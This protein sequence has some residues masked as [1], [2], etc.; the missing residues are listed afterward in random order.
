VD[1]GTYRILRALG[2]GNARAATTLCSE[3]GES[4]SVLRAL[5]ADHPEWF[6]ELE[7][8]RVRSTTVGLAA[9]AREM[10]AR[11]PRVEPGSDEEKAL[12]DRLREAGRRR[13]R[14]KRELDQVWATPETAVRRARRLIETGA[15]QRGLC[16]LGDD[17]M[18]SL[19]VH[20]LGVER[21]VTVIDMDADLLA[22]YEAEAEI[23]GWEHRGVHHDL[24][25][26]LPKKLRGRFGCVF[27]DPPYALEGFA[28]FVSRAVELL[29]RDGWLW[30]CS[31]FGRR[32]PERGLQKQRVL[33][34]AGLVVD[35][36]VPGE[37][38]YEGA[39]SIGSESA[40]II[41]RMTPEARPLVRGSVD[42]DLY[43]RRT[44]SH[45]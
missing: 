34:D 2:D 23:G 37:N 10:V 19:A 1:E 41:C 33:C 22:L 20:G 45:E 43:S 40:L 21:S 24:R 9:L 31:G 30:V 13:G 42:G 38:R 29:R 44:P 15:A 25:R 11:T 4:P 14:V 12:C 39:L 18:T 16:F 28:L 8:G 26:P 36:V 35:E 5:R 27:T 6:E 32:A 7:P 3:A 17:D